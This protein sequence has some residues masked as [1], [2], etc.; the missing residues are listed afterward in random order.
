MY[1]IGSSLNKQKRTRSNPTAIKIAPI[2][3]TREFFFPIYQTKRKM[4][5]AQIAA[6]SIDSIAGRIKMKRKFTTL[7][8]ILHVKFWSKNFTYYQ[9]ISK[10]NSTTLELCFPATTTTTTTTND[11]ERRRRQ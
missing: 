5:S 11:D 4:D 3:E 10:C 1:S 8:K 6:F 9:I 2:E 7:V